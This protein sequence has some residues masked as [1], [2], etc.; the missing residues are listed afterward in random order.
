MSRVNAAIDYCVD[1]TEVLGSI[2]FVVVWPFIVLDMKWFPLIRSGAALVGA[3][4]IVIF[5]VVPQ[6]QV[7]IILG[8]QGNLQSISTHF[9]SGTFELKK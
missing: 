8:E 1:S 9:R 7:Y 6:T 3:T 5:V 4:L 2:I